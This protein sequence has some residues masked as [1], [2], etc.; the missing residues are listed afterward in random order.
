MHNTATPMEIQEQ[1]IA[2]PAR[3]PR[4]DAAPE[5]VLIRMPRAV[6]AML[7]DL[8]EREAR[9]N[10][11]ASLSKTVGKLIQNEYIRLTTGAT[12]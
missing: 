3:K 10:S 4:L 1:S 2:R 7:V 8:T 9:T 5:K 11:K 6:K 12:P